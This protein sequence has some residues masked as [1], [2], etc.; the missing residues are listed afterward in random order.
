MK[1]HG[2]FLIAGIL[3]LIALL[4]YLFKGVQGNTDKLKSL[5]TST[6]TTLAGVTKSES[7]EIGAAQEAVKNQ[8]GT[9]TNPEIEANLRALYKSVPNLTFSSTERGMIITAMGELEVVGKNQSQIQNHLES[10]AQAYGIPRDQLSPAV[11]KSKSDFSDVYASQQYYQGF[12]VYGGGVQTTI[13]NKTGV[14][15]MTSAY[16]YPVVDV[17]LG[18]K[19]AVEEAI[20]ILKS[21]FKPSEITI[22]SSKPSTVV[23]S[24]EDPRKAQLGYVFR[25]SVAGDS[26]KFIEAIVGFVSKSVIYKRPLSHT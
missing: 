15:F 9:P 17:D 2:Y 13:N 20:E 7:R 8:S 25:I 1:R 10:F 23:Y 19:L 12:E 24:M 22:T 14:A 5:E 11:A 4:A 18:A 6:T 16:L 26:A 21:H 3:V